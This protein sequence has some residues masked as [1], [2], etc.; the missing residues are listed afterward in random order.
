MFTTGKS[1]EEVKTYAE[2]VDAQVNSIDA[3]VLRFAKKKWGPDGFAASYTAAQR[4]SF[5]RDKS[6]WEGWK[7]WRDL[8]KAKKADIDSSWYGSDDRYAEIEKFDVE[9]KAWRKKWNDLGYYLGA[10]TTAE[11]KKDAEGK[12]LI[13]HPDVPGGDMDMMNVALISLTVAALG[14]GSYAFFKKRKKTRLASNAMA[15]MNSVAGY[16]P[17]RTSR[18]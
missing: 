11:V 14:L 15:E 9:A 8:W 4:E 12:D 17:V 7:R 10:P 3:D 2:R 5:L 18:R 6:S 1:L 13:S 16:L